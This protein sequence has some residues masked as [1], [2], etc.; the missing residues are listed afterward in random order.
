MR[1]LE[2]EPLQISGISEQLA[3]AAPKSPFREN[4]REARQ[5]HCDWRRSD[6]RGCVLFTNN[7]LQVPA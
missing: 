2:L 3:P 7:M 6:A 1:A 5:D 4:R